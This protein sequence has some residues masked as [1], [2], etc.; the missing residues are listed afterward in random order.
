MG[1]RSEAKRVFS[2][3]LGWFC[4]PECELC[5]PGKI[6]LEPWGRGVRVGE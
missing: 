1:V 3:V 2:V 5:K 4:T 6:G